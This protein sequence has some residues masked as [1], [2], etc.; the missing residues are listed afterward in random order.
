ML[1]LT[2]H[3]CPVKVILFIKCIWI[4][5]LDEARWRRCF[6]S[7]SEVLVDESNGLKTHGS[8]FLIKLVKLTF[9]RLVA[10]PWMAVLKVKLDFLNHHI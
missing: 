9:V 5:G 8:G 4:P 6:G 7:G 3:H 1:V 10:H 2:A